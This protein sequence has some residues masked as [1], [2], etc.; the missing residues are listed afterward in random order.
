MRSDF[1]FRL[2]C[3]IV[4]RVVVDMMEVDLIDWVECDGYDS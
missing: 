4:D 2:F 1:D 3:L